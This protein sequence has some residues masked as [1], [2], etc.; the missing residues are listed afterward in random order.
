MATKKQ[1]IYW[2]SLKGRKLSKEHKEKIGKSLRGGNKTSFKK[3]QHNSTKTE[4]KKGLTPW[5]KGKPHLRGDKHWN[6]QGGISLENDKIRHS[7]ESKLWQGS[8]FGRDGYTCQKCKIKGCY[9]VA[10][11]IQNFAQCPELRTSI[12]NGITFCRDCHKEFHKK[13]G[14]RNNTKEQLIEFLYGNM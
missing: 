6:W 14:R 4:F 7:I 5:N 12:E 10:H 13:Y 11:H 2:E 8:I 9:L 3:G 1:I